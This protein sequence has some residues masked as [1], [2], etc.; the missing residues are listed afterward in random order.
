MHL[1][2]LPPGVILIC[3]LQ[4]LS[5]APSLKPSVFDRFAG[6]FYLF[7]YYFFYFTAEKRAGAM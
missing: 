2:P 5:I 3:M 7:G 6:V 4:H 1:H